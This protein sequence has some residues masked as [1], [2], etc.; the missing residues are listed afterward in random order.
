M[1]SDTWIGDSYVSVS[2][3]WVP[4]MSE[5]QW[6]QSGNRWWYKHADG[7]YTKSNWEFIN[8]KWYYFDS[9]G[10]MVTGWRWIGSSCYY[11]V[12]SGEMASDT[13][14]GDSYVS[15]SGA[16][17]PNMSRAQWIQSGNRWW[18][19]HADGSY[20]K[21]NWEFINGKWYYFDSEGWMVTGWRWI[22][23]SCYYFASSGEMASDTWIDGYYVDATGKWVE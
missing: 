8:G 14:I 9:E 17:V 10:W 1:A 21:S 2:G 12:S 5:A 19:K 18:Y 16:W 22:G 3:A 15:V 7:S 6:I 13:W 4:N 23:G 11:F 20:T